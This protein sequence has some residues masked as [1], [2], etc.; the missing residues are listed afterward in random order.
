LLYMCTQF[1]IFTV[2]RVSVFR[3]NVA[4]QCPDQISSMT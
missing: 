4:A 2:A 3:K 1:N